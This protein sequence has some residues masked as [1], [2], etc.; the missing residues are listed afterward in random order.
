MGGRLSI[1]G[2]SLDFYR[3]IKSLKNPHLTRIQTILFCYTLHYYFHHFSIILTKNDIK[4][5]IK[6]AVVSTGTIN[7]IYCTASQDKPE[8]FTFRSMFLV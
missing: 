5:K 8:C 2:T 4:T 7:K 3:A 1:L 6:V